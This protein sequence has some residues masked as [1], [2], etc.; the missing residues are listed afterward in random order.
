MILVDALIV[1]WVAVNVAV[2]LL[3]KLIDH[4][5]P[6][7]QAGRDKGSQAAVI[8]RPADRGSDR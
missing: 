2:S 4:V 1:H 3:I 8:S 6:R 5:P 7:D